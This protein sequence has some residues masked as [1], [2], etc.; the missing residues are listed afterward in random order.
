MD[1]IGNSM[2]DQIIAGNI[3]ILLESGCHFIIK[4]NLRRESKGGWFNM[5]QE[6]SQNMKSPREGKTVYIGSDRKTV[7]YIAGNGEHKTVTLHT[8]Y[9]II[10]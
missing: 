1:D 10:E 8:G 7:S 9:E 3:G 4:R 6:L 5:A 2:R